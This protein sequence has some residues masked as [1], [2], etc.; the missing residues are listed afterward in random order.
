MTDKPGY[1]RPQEG[2]QPAYLHPAYQS[3]NLR[4]PSQPL[5]FLPHSLSEIT[6]PTIGAERIKPRTTT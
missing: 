1:R 3:T 5:V 4:A 2:T 6:G